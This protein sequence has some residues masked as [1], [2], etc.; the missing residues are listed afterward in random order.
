MKTRASTVRGGLREAGIVLAIACGA[1]LLVRMF[2]FQNFYVP[3]VSMLDTLRVDDKIVA[4]KITT[5]MRG[6]QRGDVVVFRDPGGWLSAPVTLDGWRGSLQ[7]G[8]GFVGFLPSDT[9]SDLV[10]RV[11]GVGGD[12]VVCC[13][14]SGG[15][16][17]NGTAIDESAYVIGATN[18]VTF[19][20]T[21]PE[22]RLF[23]MGDNRQH[24]SDSRFHLD[25]SFGTVPLDLVKG[26]VV[27]RWWPLSRFGAIAQSRSLQT[28]K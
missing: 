18:D 8:L 23:V 10:K 3:S 25:V 16:V 27:L 28:A 17:I 20:I 13:S 15:L 24:S 26:V 4:S 21:V 6:V 7:R 11:I 19:D 14:P 5:T 2:L 12:H 22:G 9:G 1:S